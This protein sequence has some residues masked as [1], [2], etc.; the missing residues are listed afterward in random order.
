MAQKVAEGWVWGPVKDP[1][2]KQHPCIVPYLNLPIAQRRKD[3]LF[4]AIV[5]ALA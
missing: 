2:Q 4:Y 1:A 5:G 3:A